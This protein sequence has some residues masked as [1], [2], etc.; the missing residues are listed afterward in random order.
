MFLKMAK[1][2]NHFRDKTVEPPK[3]GEIETI[4]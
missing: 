4:F 1:G 2:V 3:K